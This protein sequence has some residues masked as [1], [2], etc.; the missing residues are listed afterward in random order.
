[1]RYSSDR[2]A[3]GAFGARFCALL[4]FVASAIGAQA[5]RVEIQRSG[6][7]SLTQVDDR[8]TI[9]VRIN[10]RGPYRFGIETG[11]PY[12]AI[13]GPSFAA[14]IGLSGA[15]TPGSRSV[16]DSLRA[17][18]VLFRDFEIAVS[19]ELGIPGVDG[20]L[21]LDAFKGLLLAIDFP[22]SVLRV[23]RDTLPAPN[24]RTILPL[25]SM[26]GLVGVDAMLGGTSALLLVDTQG[27]GQSI[28]CQPALVSSLSFDGPSA[29]VGQAQVGVGN[30]APVE[31]R[32][33]RLS[34]DVT[35]GGIVVPQP[36]MSAFPLPDGLPCI[37]GLALLRRYA[38][39]LDQRT[40]RI[41]LDGP[42]VL[43]RAPSLFS[44]G[45]NIGPAADGTLRVRVVRPGSGADQGGIRVG[46]QVLRIDGTP[47]TAPNTAPAAIRALAARGRPFELV[48]QR[49]GVSQTIAVAP[50]VLVR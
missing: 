21:G 42:M 50:Q 7:V 4:A 30:P 3:S 37:L 46:D 2:E 29:V 26:G 16:V 9:D 44:A 34:G 5:P 8:P 15:Q 45:L 1:M 17:G 43:P 38:V 24:G 47:A 48:V 39:T 18:D 10:G 12:R 35:F 32:A 6:T 28:A 23:T 31:L 22:G 14:R 25:R 19:G 41:A 33:G 13:V 36:I 49:D 27:S 11:A 40:M 20:M